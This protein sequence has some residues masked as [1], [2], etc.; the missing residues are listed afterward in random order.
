MML[1]TNSQKLLLAIPLR[2]ETA[3]VFAI[4]LGLVG[5]VLPWEY[6]FITIQDSFG[7][8]TSLVIDRM[9]LPRVAWGCFSYFSYLNGVSLPPSWLTQGYGSLMFRVFPILIVQQYFQKFGS[10]K[11]RKVPLV[12]IIVF[13]VLYGYISYLLAPDPLTCGPGWQVIIRDYSISWFAISVPVMSALLATYA[14]QKRKMF[15]N[16]ESPL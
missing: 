4:I 7:V 6:L 13:A 1:K 14:Y 12:S 15:D 5:G 10:K 11:S 3:V 16:L 9:A 2:P 8:T